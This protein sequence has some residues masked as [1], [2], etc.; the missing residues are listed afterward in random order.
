MEMMLMPKYK[1]RLLTYTQ[2]EKVS[3]EKCVYN[4]V[5]AWNMP[6]DKCGDQGG[7][8]RIKSYYKPKSDKYAI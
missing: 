5:D 8:K 1:Y 3:C 2:F 4:L 6:C 7:T